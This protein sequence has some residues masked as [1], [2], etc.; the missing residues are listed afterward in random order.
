MD[1]NKLAKK[2]Q[3]P[4]ENLL[5]EIGTLAKTKTGLLDLSIGD[6]DLVTNA[7]IIDQAAED[8]KKGHTRYTA[9]NGSDEFLQAVV[10]H[11][12]KKYDLNFKTDQVFASV[13]AL[14]GTYLALMAILDPQ[15]EVIIH[16]PF[17]SPYKEQVELAGGKA[18]IV[19]TYEKDGFQLDPEILQKAINKKTK[20]IIINSPNNPTGAVFSKKTVQKIAEIAKENNLFVLSDEI[21]EEFV[22]QG[23][24]TPMAKWAFDNTIT[25]SGFSKAFAM[26]GWRIGYIIAPVYVTQAMK[27]INENIAYS[28]PTLSQRAGIYALNHAD[29]LVSQVVDVFKERLTYVKK[30]VETI[31]FLELTDVKGSM[32]AFINVSKTGLNSVDFSKK[33]LDEKQVLVIPGK[34][35]GITTGDQHVRLAATQDMTVLKEAFDRIETMKF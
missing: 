23:E 4:A 22:Y 25:I 24:F 7:R 33:L 19:P 34:A 8:A 2:F 18:V 15:D 26:T 11:Y 16:E 13:G 5:M 17:F 21:Y 32:Y 10:D 27:L 35:F 30:R 6:P 20:A 14:H 12:K 9:S 3:E 1:K 31:D 28:A 29:E